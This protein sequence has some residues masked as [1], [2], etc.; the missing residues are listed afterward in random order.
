MT[1]V[2]TTAID[3]VFDVHGIDATYTPQ[4]ESPVTVRVLRSAGDETLG[5]GETRL[6]TASNIFEIRRSEPITPQDGDT[7][8]IEGENFIIQGSPQVRDTDRLV[9][10]ME[11]Y[12]A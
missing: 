10:T 6:H 2:G 1:P 4:G 9:W 8:T 7:I 11:A 3:A 5:F 12:P